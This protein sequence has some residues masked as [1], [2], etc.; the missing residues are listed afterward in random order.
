[1]IQKQ[2][3]PDNS[4]VSTEDKATK[5]EFVKLPNVDGMVGENDQLL[6]RVQQAEDREKVRSEARRNEYTKEY[7]KVKDICRC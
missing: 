3:P 2:I 7:T 5:I 1:M 4:S 6:L